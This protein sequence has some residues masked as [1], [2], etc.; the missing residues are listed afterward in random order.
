MI[1][2]IN[3]TKMKKHYYLDDILKICEHKHLTVEKIYEQ[4]KKKYP[5]A[6]RATIY[7]SVW[8]L[9]EQ[10]KLRKIEVNKISYYETVLQNHFHVIDS[11]TG[12]IMDLPPEK[13]VD[14]INNL[15]DRKYTLNIILE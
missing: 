1:F 8:Y 4:I 6:W 10:W 2:I 14:F 11:K 12:E 7:R 9:V 5:N 13:V 3:L 15:K